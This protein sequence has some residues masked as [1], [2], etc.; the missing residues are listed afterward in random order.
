[1]RRSA[2][3]FREPEQRARGRSCV[4]RSAVVLAKERLQCGPTAVQVGRGDCEPRQPLVRKSAQGGGSPGSAAAGLPVTPSAYLCF[5]TVACLVDDYLLA[6]LASSGVLRAD[7]PILEAWMEMA[8]KLVPG[9]LSGHGVN[10][11]AGVR[12][13]VGGFGGPPSG[14][15][16][17]GLGGRGVVSLRCPASRGVIADSGAMKAE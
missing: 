17:A 16:P 15:P 11:V 4:N 14:L 12:C 1:V 7:E 9:R 8:G 2:G 3:P 10:A 5:R 6:K 13:R